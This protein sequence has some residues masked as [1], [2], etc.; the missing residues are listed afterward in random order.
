MGGRRT[1]KLTKWAEYYFD[2]HNRYNIQQCIAC[3]QGDPGVTCFRDSK[4]HGGICPIA[5]ADLGLWECNKLAYEIYAKSQYS[6]VQVQTDQ[7][8]LIYVHGGDI[9]AYMDIY[10]VP[11]EDREAILE[12]IMIVQDIAN[13]KRPTRKKS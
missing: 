6:G 8:T 11:M 2:P 4:H 10:G 9:R 7:K 13:S 1:G 3:H 12:K 5:D